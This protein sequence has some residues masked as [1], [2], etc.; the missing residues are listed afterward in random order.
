MARQG[1]GRHGYGAGVFGCEAL[2]SRTLLSAA[3]SWTS[4]EVYML[5]LVNRA[6]ANPVA[7]GQRL[8][9][10]LAAALTPG[11]LARLVPQEPLALNRELTLAAR[12]HAEDMA[13]RGYFAHENPDGQDPTDRARAAGYSFSAGENIAAGFETIDDIHRAWLDSLGHRKNVLSLHETF[14]ETFHY[15]EFGFGMYIP[16]D[17]APYRSYFAQSYGYQ[18]ADPDVYLLGVVYTDGNSDGF[19]TMGEGM[20]QVRVEARDATAGGLVFGAY[21]TDTKGNYQIA[22][23]AGRFVVTFTQELT[24]LVRQV[25]VEIGDENVKVDA[26]AGQFVMP[27][28]VDARAQAGAVVAGSTREDGRATI[29]T[30]GPTGSPIALEEGPDGTWTATDL[31]AS[32]ATSAASGQAQTWTDPKDG[33]T[34][35]ALPS[36]GGLLLF[37]RSSGGLWSVRNL[38]AEAGGAP[39]P[40]SDIAVFASVDGLMHIAGMTQ[41]G[42]LLLYAQDGNAGEEGYTWTFSNLSEELSAQGMDTPSLDGDLIGFATSWNALNIAGLNEFG[43]IHAVWKA[44]GMAAWRTDNLSAITGAP[45]LSGGLNSYLTGWGAINLAGADASGKVS[46]T[47][48][49]PGGVW[50][51]SNLSD[52]F[53]GPSLER[54]SLA[55]Y[56]TPWGG[57]NVVGLDERGDLV[58]YWWAPGMSEWVVTN[59]SAF[60]ESDLRPAGVMR[61]VSASNGTISLLSS[62]EDGDIVRFWWAPGG[63]WTAENLSVLA[64]L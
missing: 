60:I 25:S 41:S 42:A 16:F 1:T 22:L 33:R 31:G 48:W 17:D 63:S 55:S 10:D 13:A 46:V 53:G 62:E 64:T 61:G 9:L 4:E 58:V 26:E 49:V 20:D 59:M 43:E 39:E 51:T 21:T 24:G 23:P 54:T 3:F 12:R 50:T 47:W 40:E 38:S 28:P 56:V 7:E 6:R 19:Y 11:E 15:D 57:L 5:E 52:M 14:D 35:A 27:A 8:G 30:L 44:P 37:T 29:V 2:E 34:Y 32:L 36:D 18:G 45:G